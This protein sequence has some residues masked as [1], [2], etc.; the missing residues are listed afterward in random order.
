MP[1]LSWASKS[2]PEYQPSAFLTD[3]VVYPHG[4]GYGGSPFPAAGLDL[5]A[6][7]VNT[8]IL[9]DN[10]SGMASLLPE[11]EGRLA[12]I[13]ADPP[14]FT[15]RT[16]PA[17]VGRGEDSRRPR[18]WQLAEGYAD[19]WPDLEA[20][21]D[22]LYPRLVLMYRLLSPTGSLYLHLDWHADAY[23]RLLLDEIFG[24]E[25]LLNEIIW[26]YHGPSPIRSAFN[27]KHDTLLVYTKSSQYTFNVD[28]VRQPYDPS[29]FCISI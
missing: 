25:R 17:R 7:P 28:A 19:H 10:L 14:F 29:S 23:A 3:S 4:S 5:E 24:P 12:L 9:G 18:E 2:L 11:Y 13:Y 8:L 16:Y 21:L 6:L 26:C 20:Y 27:R 1:T 22:F 15:N